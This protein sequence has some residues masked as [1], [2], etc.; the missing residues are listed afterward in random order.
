MTLGKNVF[1]L[2]KTEFP[3]AE[4]I[5]LILPL[6][7]WVLESACNQIAAWADRKETANVTISVNI[8]AKQLH[9]PDFVEKVLGTLATSGA[10]PHSLE[11]ELTE[12]VD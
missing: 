9:Q 3:F 7:N 2:L 8:S 4:E 10:N 1:E 12:H 6:G 5:G 11:L